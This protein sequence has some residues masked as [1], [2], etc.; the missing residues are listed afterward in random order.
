MMP[1]MTRA[2]AMMKT[3]IHIT[4]IMTT[5]HTWK[6]DNDTHTHTTAVQL[7]MR[8]NDIIA[9]NMTLTMTIHKVARTMLMTTSTE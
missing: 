9:I 6:H 5:I 3:T 4:V 7:T 2:H 1:V 8:L